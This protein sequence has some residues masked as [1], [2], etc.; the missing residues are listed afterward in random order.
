MKCPK[1][2]YLGFETG[3]R[4]KNCG[5]DFSLLTEA[6]LSSSSPDLPLN[7]PSLAGPNDWLHHLDRGLDLTSAPAAPFAESSRDPLAGMPV[8][9]AVI[10]AT[11]TSTR[12]ASSA[13]ARPAPARVA[14]PLPLFQRGGEEDDAPLIKLPPAPRPPL[15]VRRTP[16]APRLRAVPKTVRRSGAEA[17]PTQLA[18]DPDLMLFPEETA[19]TPIAAEPPAVRKRPRGLEEWP[20]S[21]A[22]RRVVAALLD[23]AILLGIDGVVIYLTVQMAALTIDQWRLLPAVPLLLFLGLVK[24]A[25]FSAF[26]LVGGQTV[27]KMAT[28]IRVVTLDGLQ[29]DPARA[30][31][32]T[33]GGVISLGLGFIPVLFTSDRRALHDRVARTRVVDIPS[34]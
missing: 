21:G 13:P 22:G 24:V 27:G 34:I 2:D 12:P 23:H 10:P 26:T 17:A 29:L 31:G 6:A 25:Y 14:P 9:T 32:R 15:A 11:T 19:D 33:L 1:C 8:D 28:G 7:E 4:C 3:D 5:Y 20:T 16:D 18:A 30:M